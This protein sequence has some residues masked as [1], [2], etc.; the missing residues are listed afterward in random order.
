MMTHSGD[1]LLSPQWAGTPIVDLTSDWSILQRFLEIERAW[2]NALAQQGI[3]T[4]ATRGAL[5]KVSITPALVDSMAEGSWQ[6]GNPA[7]GFVQN[8]STKLTDDARSEAVFHAGLTSQ[9]LVD[10]AMM[11]TANAALNN[12]EEGLTDIASS[13]AQLAEQCAE[14]VCVTRTLTRYAEPSLLGFRFATW[15]N[16]I[17]DATQLVE[18]TRRRLPV[19]AGGAVGNQAVMS[20]L[21]GGVDVARLVDQLATTLGLIS[22]RAV[23]H[24]NRQPILMV[25]HALAVASA[26][27]GVIAHNLVALGRP[28]VGELVELV[29]D[30]Q[31]T[32]SAMPHKK[33]PTRSILAHSVS[34]RI[35]GL[36]AQ[37][38]AAATPVAERGEGQWNAEW[39]PVR[40][41]MRLVAGQS[42]HL[43]AVLEGLHIDD[44]AIARNLAGASLPSSDVSPEA[45]A[46][47]ATEIRRSVSVARGLRE[48]GQL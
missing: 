23:W 8:L 47:M 17:I 1:S 39:E 41:L 44:D 6:A 5:A 36:M 29:P 38:Q 28:E 13:L 12:L 11:M 37:I 16:A 18:Q 31:G 43:S 26:A 3:G 9:D 24:T 35:P 45:R 21:G 15:L 34:H 30:G 40:E 22:P 2:L 7:V 42:H 33:N 46:H 25:A 20:Q 4:E 48:D 19:Q 10:T 32:S 14:T 27:L